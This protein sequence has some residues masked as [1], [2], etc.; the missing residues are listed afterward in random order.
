MSRK[1][2]GG[3]IVQFRRILCGQDLNR[4]NDRLVVGYPILSNAASSFY[5]DSEAF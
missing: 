1:V 2:V 5:G 4:D 3:A